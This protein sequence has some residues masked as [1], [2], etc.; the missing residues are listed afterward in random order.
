MATTY[1]SNYH[2]GKQTDK[3]DKFNMTVITDNMDIIDAA[4]ADKED[5]PEAATAQISNTTLE[6]F[7][8]GTMTGE[9]AAEITGSS[10]AY[11]IVRAYTLDT[12]VYMQIAEVIDGTRL[13]RSC[14]SGSWSSWT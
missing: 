12:S 14:T 7:F 11:G 8:S 13:T 5:K 10:A 1:T 4:L 3:A 9:L 6:E 2:L